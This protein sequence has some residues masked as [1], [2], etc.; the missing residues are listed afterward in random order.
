[1]KQFGP[2]Q[3]GKA[4]DYL[5]THARRLEFLRWEFSIG[6]TSEIQ[7]LAE[8]EK[9]R[10][11]DGGFGNA[12]EPDLRSRG[13]TVLATLEALMIMDEL[14]ISYDEP[15]LAGLLTWLIDPAGGYNPE[16]RL[17][18]YLP[19]DL[20][21]APRAP[22]W[23]PESLEDTFSGFLINPKAR[24]LS[25]LYKW[26]VPDIRGTS[27]VS[28]G[29]ELKTVVE[30]AETLPD[31][32]SP[33]TLRSLLALVSVKSLPENWRLRIRTVVERMISAS[34]ET[35]PGKWNEY[36]LQPLEV[37]DA[38]DSPWMS[39]LAGS[40]PRHLD[41]LIE[42]QQPDGSWSPF[43]NWS[44]VHP[45]AWRQARKEWAGIL[46]FRNLKCLRAFGR[47]SSGL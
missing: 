36:C 34:V 3:Y 33:D 28:P 15:I 6:E 9:F 47:F 24:V 26:P 44:G 32:V 1:M 43:W 13:S 37:A 12:L 8:L 7:V 23:E 4:C 25:Y 10:N 5:R 46:T 21:D 17:W 18:P 39:L 2:D 38:P 42:T 29:D 45:D 19:P 31:K 11:T 35:D 22:W 40:I 16:R 41:Y 20:D 30:L 27:G 14:G